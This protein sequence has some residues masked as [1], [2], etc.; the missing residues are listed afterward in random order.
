M[1]FDN[2]FGKSKAPEQQYPFKLQNEFRV[3][4]TAVARREASNRDKSVIDENSFI[5]YNEV[6]LRDDD[7]MSNKDPTV[8][9]NDLDEKVRRNLEKYEFKF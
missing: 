6:S 5:G 3:P 4:E 2:K 9:K 1:G 7:E 8:S